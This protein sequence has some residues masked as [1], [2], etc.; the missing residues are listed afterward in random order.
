VKNCVK[1]YGSYTNDHR[2]YTKQIA[3]YFER[4]LGIGP[5][6]Y[7]VMQK[8]VTRHKTPIIISLDQVE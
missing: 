4:K 7:I 3:E 8:S 2:N 5:L 1:N 6:S